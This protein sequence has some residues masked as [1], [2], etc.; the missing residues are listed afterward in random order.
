[1]AELGRIFGIEPEI[2]LDQFLEQI[3]LLF[4]GETGKFLLE[5]APCVTALDGFSQPN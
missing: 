5:A 4:F 1:M 3:A 2:G